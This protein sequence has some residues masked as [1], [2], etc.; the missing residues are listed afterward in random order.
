MTVAAVELQELIVAQ[1]EGD[2][3]IMAELTAMYDQVPETR[4]FPYGTFG[5]RQRIRE[6]A[7]GI[8]AAAHRIQLDFYTQEFG[9]IACEKIVGM[10]VKKFNQQDFELVDNYVVGMVVAL[11]SVTPDLAA[12]THH[13][14]VIIEALIGETDA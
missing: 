5:P 4:Q 10:V 12:E 11:D 3:A 13:G 8:S 9:A 6:D 1:I 7:E 14:V 2:A